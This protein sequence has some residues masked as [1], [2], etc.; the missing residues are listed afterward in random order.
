M[1]GTGQRRGVFPAVLKARQGGEYHSSVLTVP[2]PTPTIPAYGSACIGIVEVF[3]HKVVTVCAENPMCG[4]VVPRFQCHEL[5]GG[6]P[7]QMM[8]MTT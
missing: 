1:A 4:S 8:R 6:R 7:Q 5:S 2:L 3:P